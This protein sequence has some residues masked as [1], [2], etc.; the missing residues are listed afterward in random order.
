MKKYVIASFLLAIVLA[1]CGQRGP[2]VT[3]APQFAQSAQRP[4]ATAAVPPKTIGIEL[5]GEGL[6]TVDDAK[7]GLVGGYTQKTRSQIVAFKPG[8]TIT[9]LNLS[10]SIPHT[11][12]VFSVYGFPKNPTLNTTAS[13]GPFQLGYRSGTLFPGKS[14]TVTLSKPGIYFVGCAFHYPDVPSMRDVIKVLANATP[15][16]QATPTP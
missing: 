11:L 7:Y 6:G 9:L 10:H 14:V 5:P 2:G 15:G 4:A 1:A 8:I 3:P 16:P 13:G 12:N